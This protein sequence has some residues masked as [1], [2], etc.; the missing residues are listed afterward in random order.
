MTV[1]TIWCWM[2]NHHNW[3]WL[4]TQGVK[5]AVWRRCK[6]CGLED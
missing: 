1:G 2:R 5:Y 3:Q 4:E 6:T